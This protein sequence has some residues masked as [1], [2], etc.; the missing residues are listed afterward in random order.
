MSSLSDVIDSHIKATLNNMYT[1]IPA[2]V[3]KVYTVEKSTILDVLPLVN[4]V[5]SEGNVDMEN[6]LQEVPVVWPSGGGFRIE[7]PIEKGDN[8]LLHFAMKSVVGWKNSDGK[9]PVT[10]TNLRKFN[11]NDA[12][13]VPCIYPFGNGSEIDTEALKMGSDEMV[14]RITK[15]G[16]IELGEGATEALVLGTTFLDLFNQHTH[17]TGVG[18]SGPPTQQMVAGTHTSEV[19]TTK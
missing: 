19:V 2:V 16:T 3:E 12:F 6:I 5:S 7:A 8:V 1:T 4:K 18:P 15:Q 17:P 10:P 14:I 11:K 13:A 9:K